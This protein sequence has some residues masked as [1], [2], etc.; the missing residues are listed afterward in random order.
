MVRGRRLLLFLLRGRLPILLPLLVFGA[1]LSAARRCVWNP[2]A[3][4]LLL[5][6]PLI[7]LLLPLR[8]LLLLSLLLRSLLLLLLRLRP[9]N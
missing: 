7:K 8:S 3:G 1:V 9:N 2:L 4:I 6:L 5:C